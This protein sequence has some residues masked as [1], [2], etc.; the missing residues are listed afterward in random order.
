MAGRSVS[1]DHGWPDEQPGHPAYID[2]Q[3]MERD[4][5]RRA[6]LPNPEPELPF[7]KKAPAIFLGS[8]AGC[9][10]G[11]ILARLIFGS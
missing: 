2:R 8:L 10:I 6:R 4:W 11:T 1:H 3:R 9:A 7:H 5:R